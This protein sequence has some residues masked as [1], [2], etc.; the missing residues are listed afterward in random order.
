[1]SHLETA[2][3]PRAVSGPG[4]RCGGR[5]AQRGPHGQDQLRTEL[6]VEEPA[7]VGGAQLGAEVD[8]EIG[9]RAKK[10]RSEEWG[11]V[12]PVVRWTNKYKAS[13]STKT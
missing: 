8:L 3:P 5:V 1:M 2:C 12:R 9:A 6:R 10:W 4:V 7:E 13:K 11:E